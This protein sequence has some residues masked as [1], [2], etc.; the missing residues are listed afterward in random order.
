MSIPASKAAEAAKAAAA[1]AKVTAPGIS[2]DLLAYMQ[3]QEQIRKEERQ[4]R[5]EERAY[6]ERMRK[7]DLDRAEH[8]RHAQQKAHE[9]QIQQLTQ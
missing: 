6:L 9:L 8:E 2:P 5:L 3:Q 4:E 1:A 7:E